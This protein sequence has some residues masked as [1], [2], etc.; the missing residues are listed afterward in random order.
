MPGASRFLLPDSQSCPSIKGACPN[1]NRQIGVQFGISH[2]LAMNI[3]S[4]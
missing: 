2:T 1:C 3:L 4:A